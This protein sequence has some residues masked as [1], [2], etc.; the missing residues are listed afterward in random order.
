MTSCLI[1]STIVELLVDGAIDA[2]DDPKF[3]GVPTVLD[4]YSPAGGF[5]LIGTGAGA[6]ASAFLGLK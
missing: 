2:L 4:P 6:G 3:L 5:S 1:S